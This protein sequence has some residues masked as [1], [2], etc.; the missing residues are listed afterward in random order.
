MAIERPASVSRAGRP[1][2]P[3]AAIHLLA[4]A[5]HGLAEAATSTR[6]GERYASAHLAALRCAAAV[7]AARARPEM[8]GNRRSRRPRNAWS[9]LTEVAPEL[10][11]WAAFFA[12]GAAKRAAAEA[13]IQN[14]VS[15]READD[16][17]RDVETFLALAETTI[18]I[19][20]QTALTV[21]AQAS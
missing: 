3:P 17:L 12:A 1:Q 18:G 21:G 19:A 7:L 14:A 16:L 10:N 2:V 11:E 5:R 4:A 8:P 9:L 15:S 6:P 20:H 13:A